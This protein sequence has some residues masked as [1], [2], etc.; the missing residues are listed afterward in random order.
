MI[1]ENNEVVWSFNSDTHMTL[2]LNSVMTS[3][4]RLIKNESLENDYKISNMHTIDKTTWMLIYHCSDIS[5]DAVHLIRRE[6]ILNPTLTFDF[7]ING[8]ERKF[9]FVNVNEMEVTD[10]AKKAYSSARDIIN[11]LCERFF[12]NCNMIMI[13]G[14]LILINLRTNEYT[15]LDAS[16]AYHLTVLGKKLDS[17][18]NGEDNKKE[19]EIT[20]LNERI[21]A[22]G[23]KLD[24]VIKCQAAMGRAIPDKSNDTISN[25]KVLME[26]LIN[27]ER[28][29]DTTVNCQIAIEKR[30]SMLEEQ[31]SSNNKGDCNDE[32]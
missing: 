4:H 8:E 18:N 17:S 19:D 23:R 12:S 14:E 25:Q 6:G 7:T 15:N 9:K 24:T 11:D 27:L 5:Y 1:N 20:Q 16:D 26:R 28:R 30:V 13:R 3:V 22:I 31:M 21:D 10:G 2:S 32:K 29:L